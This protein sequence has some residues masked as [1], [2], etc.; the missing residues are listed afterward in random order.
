MFPCDRRWTSGKHRKSIMRVTNKCQRPFEVALIR[1]P[2]ARRV[3]LVGGSATRRTDPD[4]ALGVCTWSSPACLEEPS[5]GGEG[6]QHSNDNNSNTTT[7]ADGGGVAPTTTVTSIVY[8]GAPQEGDVPSARIGH[9]A[10]VHTS[11]SAIVLF[12]GESASAA[13]G[14]S[15]TKLPGVY[16]GSPREPSGKLVWRALIDPASGENTNLN[17]GEVASAHDAPTPLAFHAACVASVRD[18]WAMIVHGGIDGS[19]SLSGDLWAFRFRNE[20]KAHDHDKIGGDKAEFSWERL[21]PD[22]QG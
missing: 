17:T 5:S 22:G 7:A 15:P 19:S 2:N 4:I 12:G 9:A 6:Q 16:E 1:R 21:L 20:D 13:A 18:E 11:R 10:V 8:T 14:P 3:Y